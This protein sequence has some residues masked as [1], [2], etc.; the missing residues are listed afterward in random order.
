MSFFGFSHIFYE[1]HN[2]NSVYFSHLQPLINKIDP[3]AI[4]H[5]KANL[6]TRSDEIIEDSSN[7]HVDF[8]EEDDVLLDQWNTGIFYINSN[9]GY[10]KFKDGTIIESVANRFVS[11]PANTMHL[12]TSCTDEQVRIV[13]N[14][15][16]MMWSKR[17]RKNPESTGIQYYGD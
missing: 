7:F 1:R 14:F 2:Q 12:E 3:L 9:N 16:Y 15:N 6:L 5:I 13:I 11:F 4:F 8:M 17:R 10:T